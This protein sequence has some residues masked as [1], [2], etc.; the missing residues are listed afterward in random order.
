[1]RRRKW[2]WRLFVPVLGRPM[3]TT[4]LGM[5]GG[6]SRDNGQRQTTRPAYYSHSVYLDC[7]SCPSSID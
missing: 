6:S 3:W 4:Y 1:M 5:A 2:L 7:C